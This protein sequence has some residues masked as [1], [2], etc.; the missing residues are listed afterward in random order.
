M[1][2]K[3]S[4]KRPTL[5]GHLTDDCWKNAINLHSGTT[6]CVAYDNDYVYLGVT[7]PNH[8]LQSQLT[9]Q[10][11]AQFSYGNQSV[12]ERSENG[13][14]GSSSPRDQS[15]LSQDRLRIGIDID[16]DLLSTMEL[17]VTAA[18][19]VHDAI[20]GC[21]NWQPTWYPAIQS[22]EVSTTFEIAILR[23]DLST[24]PITHSETWLISV[25]CLNAGQRNA[26]EIIPNPDRLI[27][28]LFQ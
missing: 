17:Q 16:Q 6:L 22:N 24:L 12:S 11:S 3:S 15:L 14:S 27:R 5:D 28:V 8:Q 20:D 23:R 13:Q 2:A 10:T 25:S 26:T 1:V 9:E 21:E 18:G 19:K 7:V 4:E